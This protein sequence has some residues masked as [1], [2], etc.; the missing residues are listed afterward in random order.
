MWM[1]KSDSFT[2]RSTFS[3]FSIH[4]SYEKAKKDLAA[5]L[6]TL[7]AHLS[8]SA[9]LVSNNNN[10]NNNDQ[11][12]TLAD[13]VV[14]ATLLYPFKLVCDPDF[15]KPYP[16]VVQWFQNCVARPEFQRIVGTV[17]LCEKEWTAV[18]Q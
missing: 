9:Y 10:S 14:A 3:V 16:R 1:F 5:A 13:I 11:S 15:R 4:T 18:G 12:L 7:E 17:T 2:F 6:G 8:S